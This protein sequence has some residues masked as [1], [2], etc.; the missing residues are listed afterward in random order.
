MNYNKFFKKNYNHKNP[1]AML[2]SLELLLLGIAIGIL[3]AP[4]KGS[5]T[6]KKIAGSFLDLKDDAEYYLLDAT[7]KVKAKVKNVTGNIKNHANDLADEVKDQ[8][9]NLKNG[10]DDISDNIQNS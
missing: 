10:A 5:A 6:R 4:D 9:N 1:S 7:D 8:T 2:K 3:V